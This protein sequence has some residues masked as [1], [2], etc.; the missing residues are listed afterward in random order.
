VIGARGFAGR[1]AVTALAGHLH[2]RGA[3]PGD[4]LAEA[5]R[6]VDV[7]HLAVELYSP[8]KRLRWT[9]ERRPHPFLAQV[10]E[11]AR[12]AGVRRIVH[13]SS[14]AA[15]RP[16]RAWR[17]SERTRSRPEHT[18]GRLLARDEAWL[19]QLGDPEVVVLRPAQLFGPGEPLLGRLLHALAA[20][21]VRL[22]G[23]GRARR[24]FLAGPDLGQAFAAAALRGEPYAA[25]LCGGF[26]GCWA[27]LLG[28]AGA[29]LRLRG[30]VGHGSYALAHLAAAAHLPRSGRAR[31]CWP[32]PL[33]VE[34]IGRRWLVDDGWSRRE[35]SWEPGVR[36]FPEGL[37]GLADWW[38]REV[39]GPAVPP[40]AEAGP[41][42]PSQV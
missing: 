24:T 1:H 29:L 32:T 13:L 5:M 37:T 38:Y 40:V 28:A 33:L 18:Y 34:V 11:A 3:E 19:R 30:R 6:G 14:A 4:D 42:T 15:C 36:T 35:L 41:G 20:G 22:P 17:V 26:E 39:A 21:R 7:V 25:Y 2:V 8:F 27:D 23:G 9:G 16:N 12:L 31:M 10:V